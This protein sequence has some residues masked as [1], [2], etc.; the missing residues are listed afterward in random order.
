MNNDIKVLIGYT[1]NADIDAFAPLVPMPN[2]GMYLWDE[3]TTSWV[4]VPQPE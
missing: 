1:Y 3:A 4:A 2:D